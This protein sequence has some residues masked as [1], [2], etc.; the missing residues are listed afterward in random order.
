MTCTVRPRGWRGRRR[1]DGLKIGGRLAAWR[2]VADTIGRVQTLAEI[3]ALLE[4]RGLAPR[5]SLGQNFLIDKNLLAKLIESAELPRGSTVLEI[6]PGTGTLTQTLLSDEGGGHRVVAGELDGGLAA[7]LREE[8]KGFSERGRFVL[9]EGDALESGRKLNRGLVEALGP[10]RFALVA[11]LPYGAATPVMLA[12]LTG[13]PACDR[14]A[15]TIQREV[16]DRLV[17]GPGS[18]DYGTLGIVAQAVAEVSL[19]AKLPPECFWPRPE[20]SSAMVLLRRRA[21]PMTS[22]AA[23]LLVFCQRLFAARRKQLGATLGRA[24]AW[25][26]GIRAEQRVEELAIEQIVA[27]QA[28]V[29]D[30]EG[31]RGE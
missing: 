7:L 18:K 27:L 20:V 1:S 25:P 23:G 5:R 8:L 17:A 31:G 14:L 4:S 28:V 22:D 30:Q 2:V 26:A 10:G 11:N 9:V 6:G 3:R 24:I 19:V 13:H 16:A 21:V 29:G 12:L 15:V